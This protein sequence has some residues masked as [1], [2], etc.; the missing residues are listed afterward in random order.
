MKKVN[1]FKLFIALIVTATFSSF[2]LQA[3]TSGSDDLGNG[4]PPCTTPAGTVGGCTN[5]FI[6][7]AAGASNT[8]SGLN[9]SFFGDHAG[10]SSASGG[11]NTHIGWEAGYDNT[12][13]N[14]T[15]IGSSAGWSNT[16]TYNVFVG[17]AGYYNTSGGKNSFLGYQAGQQN[18][19]ASSNSALGFNSLYYNQTGQYNTCLGA[20]AGQGASLSSYSNSCFVGYQ[21]GY[22]NVANDNTA[23]GYQALY[24]NATGGLQCTAI[25]SGALYYNG[26]EANT[27]TGYHALYSNVNGGFSVANGYKALANSTSSNGGNTAVGYNSLVGNTSGYGNTAIGRGS[28]VTV[29]TMDS[30]TFAGAGADAGGNNFGNCA[31]FGAYATAPGEG[32]MMFGNGNIKGLYTSSAGL[33]QTSDG[34]FKTNIKQNVPGLE[35]INKLRPVTYNMDT[36]ALDGFINAGRSTK[37]QVIAHTQTQTFTDSTGTSHTTTTT[38]YDTIPGYTP[39]PNADF[40]ASTSI[41]HSG[42]IAQSVD[43]A[44]KAIGYTSTIVSRPSNTNDPYALNYAEFVVPLVK[45]VQELSKEVDSLK[46]A[47]LKG[48]T[49]TGNNG[50]N[51]NSGKST[52]DIKLALPDAPTLGEPQPNPNS[53]STQISYYLPDNTSGAKIIF[54]DMLGKVMEERVLQ[55]GYGLLNIDTKNL[56]SGIYSYTL[57][58]DGKVIDNKKMMRN[59]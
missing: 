25:G 39:N 58:I 49:H 15:F 11:N 54:T 27:A 38:T 9:N 17:Q 5:T 32:E 1:L 53:G 30:N 51:D 52:Q 42:F 33:F 20:Y 37:P 43:S 21:A 3:Q 7:Q 19:T 22:A 13:S 4:N 10:F 40:S 50:N 48:A 28:G 23:V 26:V 36:K 45:A 16:G 41:V 24:S 55:S 18:T 57:V 6:G 44:A 12:A 35:F 56:P 46:A 8:T 2:Q 31:A 47:N 14:N 34:R 59:K 29:T